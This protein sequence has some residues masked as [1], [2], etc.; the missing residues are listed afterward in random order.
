[1]NG[2]QTPQVDDS[3]RLVVYMPEDTRRRTR[4]AAAMDGKTVSAWVTA[5]I[6]AALAR[7]R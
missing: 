3:S 2:P 5:L 4:A 1:M 6:D 7:P